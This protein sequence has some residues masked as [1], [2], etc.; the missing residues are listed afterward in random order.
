VAKTKRN[1][2][3]D[4][5]D[6]DFVDVK[7]ACAILGGTKPWHPSTLWRAL[8]DPSRGLPRPVHT[9]PNQIRFIRK[10]LLAAKAAMVAAR[11]DAVAQ[12]EI[13]RRN[14]RINDARV[15][16]RAERHRDHVG[17]PHGGDHD[18]AGEHH[19]HSEH[20]DEETT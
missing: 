5:E 8:R 1:A 12:A 11:D 19:H 15:K 10:E 3:D 16:A 17:G 20:Q 18:R 2:V 14:Q 13:A 6:F 4:A 9:G 7:T